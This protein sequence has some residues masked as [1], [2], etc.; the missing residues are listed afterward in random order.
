MTVVS[1]ASPGTFWRCPVGCAAIALGLVNPWAALAGPFSPKLYPL[2]T[3]LGGAFGLIV[4]AT[5]A[6][7]FREITH[8]RAA[9]PGSR[10]SP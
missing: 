7:V 6:F 9:L 5:V 2:D 10:W 1:A 4:T 8:E 3:V